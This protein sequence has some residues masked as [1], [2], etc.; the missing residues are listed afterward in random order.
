[1]PPTLVVP[2]VGLAFYY[3]Y[4]TAMVH[5]FLGTTVNTHAPFNYLSIFPPSHFPVAQITTDSMLCHSSSSS[6]QLLF[7]LPLALDY[8]S[9]T[10]MY[11]YPKHALDLHDPKSTLY[12]HM[13]AKGGQ[14][15]YSE[16]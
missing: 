2:G 11:C 13:L 1:M 14:N 7:P 10:V 6:I 15:R 5:F 8:I 4:S 3:I 12:T 9:D 16:A